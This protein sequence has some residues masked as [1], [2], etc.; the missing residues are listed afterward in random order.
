METGDEV[1]ETLRRVEELPEL[2]PTQVGWI[3]RDGGYIA[4]ERQEDDAPS[5]VLV[6]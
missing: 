4:I 6:D 2:R 5:D 3:F 1:H